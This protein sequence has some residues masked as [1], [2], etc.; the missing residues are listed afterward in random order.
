MNLNAVSIGKNPPH[1]VNVVIEV[2]IGGEPIKY[3]M[4]KE[5]GALQV[6]RFLYTSMRYP[7]KLRLHPPHALGRRRSLR[8]DRRQHARDRS[9]RGDELQN[10]RRPDHGGRSRRR[11]ETAGRA[12]GK[13][14]QALCAREQLFRPAPDHDRADRAFLRALQGSRTQQVGQD[15]SL[16]RRGRGARASSSRAS[17]GPRRR[18]KPSS[19]ARDFAGVNVANT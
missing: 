10:C 16:G 19:D 15:R 17:S 9:G 1:D 2:P 7:G 5:S 3:E 14:Y 12:V 8:R 4:D 13:A 6:D 11:R 18:R